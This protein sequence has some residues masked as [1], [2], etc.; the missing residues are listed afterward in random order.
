[1]VVKVGMMAFFSPISLPFPAEVYSKSRRLARF[2]TTAV[3]C[4]SDGRSPIADGWPG[5]PA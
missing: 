5:I 2:L 4:F 3:D 1:M